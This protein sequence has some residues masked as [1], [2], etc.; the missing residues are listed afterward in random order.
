MADRL[1][2]TELDFDTIKSNLKTFLNQQTLFTDYNF[3]GAGLSILLDLLA[4][5][6][7][8]QSY[9]LN[10][11]AN[12]AFLDTALLRDSVVSHAKTLGYTPYSQRSSIASISIEVPTGTTDMGQLTLPRGF[13]F[14]SNQIDGISYNFIVLE[15]ITVTKS[16]TS[17]YFENLPIYEGQLVNYTFV[18][19]QAA[20]PDQIFTLPDSNIDIS[21][22]SISVSPSSSNTSLTFFNRAEDL[23]EVSS[24]S[25]V[26]FIQES[27]SGFFQIYF[28]NGIVGQGIPDGGVVYAN[29]IVTN[30]SNANRA[31]NFIATGVAVDSLSNSLTNFIITPLG[32]SAGGMDRES[33]DSIKYSAPLSYVSQNRLVTTKDYEIQ[34]LKTF[35]DLQAVS[36]WGGEDETPPV[37]GKVFISLMPGENYYLSE[38][39]KT[40]ILNTISSRIMLTVNNEIRDPEFLYIILNINVEYD[41]TRTMLN[42]SSLEYLIKNSVL[43]YNQT[44]LNTFS[45]KFVQSKLEE[46]INNVDNNSIVG[47]ESVVRVQKRFLPS[48]KTVQNYNINFNVPLLQRTSLNKLTSSEFSIYDSN[49]NIQIVTLEEVPDSYTGIN[50]IS[51]LDSGVNYTSVPTISITGDGQ[52]ASAIAVLNNGKIEQIDV[53]NAGTDYT[54]AV[55]NITG[56]GGYGASAV[57]VIN[58]TVGVLRAIYYTSTAKRQIVN[59]NIGTIDYNSGSVTL[60]NFNIVSISTSDG[61]MRIE[62]SAKSGIIS[63][64]KNTIISID[65]TDPFSITINAQKI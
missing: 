2:V 59:P 42:S 23:T 51:L 58:T 40:S 57:A 7:H 50:S 19:D 20:N 29:Y 6:T 13:G 38:T 37:F 22:L 12:E 33:I 36:V 28:G 25:P 55:V 26:Y 1:R 64:N 35:P 4:Y 32:A 14:L 11:V 17:Y 34:I 43:L 24:T 62:C 44:Y 54:Y 63:S 9:Y 61:L 45:S 53:V 18:Q 47:S 52:G 31:N 46:F 39:E 30:S 5:N 48:L 15:D 21:T 60:N 41:A 49:G 65:K 8:Y 3:D 27:R 16:N 10:M 56:G